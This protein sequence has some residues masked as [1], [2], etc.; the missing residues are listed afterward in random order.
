MS[1]VEA[2]TAWTPPYL[3]AD[4]VSRTSQ[5]CGVIRVESTGDSFE[6]ECRVRRA[7][8]TYRWLEVRGNPLRDADGRIVRWYNLASDIEAR[9]RIEEVLVA[10][11]SS[12]HQI[13]NAIPGFVWSTRID[14]EPEFYNQHYLDYLGISA[15]ELPDLDWRTDIHPEES[16][17][18][19][20]ASVA[21]PQGFWEPGGVRN[22]AA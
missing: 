13:I 1:L 6:V 7:D 10:S 19:L 5:I 9:K 20:G 14:G 8:G 16:C 15:E 18:T 17:P 12:L 4:D 22:A 21:V 11:E 3:H 2:I